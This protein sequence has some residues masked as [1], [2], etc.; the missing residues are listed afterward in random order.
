[1][2]QPA[3]GPRPAVPRAFLMLSLLWAVIAGLGWMLAGPTVLH[4]RWG[5]QTLA[6]TH[7]MT[8]GVLANAMLGALLQFMPAAAGATLPRWTP[9]V[10]LPGLNLGLI[11]LLLH[12]LYVSPRAAWLAALM[13]GFGIGLPAL[14]AL[15]AAARA[16][17]RSLGRGLRLALTM[18][19]LTVV[20]GLWLLGLR[21]G[22]WGGSRLLLID[23]HAVLG[24]F[25]WVLGLLLCV[26]CL[27]L[28]MLQGTRALPAASLDAG[29]LLIL[30]SLGPGL[31]ARALEWS[32]WPVL[33]V[34]PLLAACSAYWRLLRRLAYRRNRPLRGFWLA[35]S[36]VLAAAGLLWTMGPPVLP[37]GA[38]PATALLAASLA[39]GCGL[40][41]LVTGMALEILSFLAWIDLQRCSVRGQRVPGVHSLLRDAPKWWVLLAQLGA[42][43]GLLAAAL[44]PQRL[45]LTAGWLFVAAHALA[46]T[47]AA[48][49]GRRARAFLAGRT[50]AGPFPEHRIQDSRG[51]CQ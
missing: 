30:A 6:L 34:L 8:L 5:A 11:A 12:L 10:L 42:G 3:L 14:M 29:A 39:L 25:G 27:T 1:M 20:F 28:P 37:W 36:L 2:L 38:Q 35:G 9:A 49:P 41:L 31:V 33:L 19:L 47:V 4:S 32:L 46:L 21:S 7:V 44:W 16:R 45:H 26:G 15:R 43:A 22:L 50:A 51:E 48:L 13:L 40:P 18:L 23:V 17:P 24:L